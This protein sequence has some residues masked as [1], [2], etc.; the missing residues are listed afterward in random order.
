M[1]NNTWTERFIKERNDK[2]TDIIKQYNNLFKEISDILINENVQIAIRSDR[3]FKENAFK[4]YV[5][6]KDIFNE[7]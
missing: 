3:E 5:I 2:N 6:L 7:K 4:L 1:E